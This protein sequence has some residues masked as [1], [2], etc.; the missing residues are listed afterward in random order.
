MIKTSDE[1]KTMTFEN[2]N[3]RNKL[4][5]RPNKKKQRSNIIA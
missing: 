2:F 1:I 3:S 5:E 4:I